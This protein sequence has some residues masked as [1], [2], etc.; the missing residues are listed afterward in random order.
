MHSDRL[1][2]TLEVKKKELMIGTVL[3]KQIL[4]KSFFDLDYPP[5][6]RICVI[7]QSPGNGLCGMQSFLGPVTRDLFLTCTY[8]Q[9]S[10][11]V[12]IYYAS[13]HSSRRNTVKLPVCMGNWRGLWWRANS[14]HTSS[15][16]PAA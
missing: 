9:C 10:H 3:Q 4:I 12:T 7:D 5:L 15:A 11:G 6:G 16:Y 8:C 2:F 14:P 13:E 1:N